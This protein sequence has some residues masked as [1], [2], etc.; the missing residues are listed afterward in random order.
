MERDSESGDLG[1]HP[2][3][4]LVGFGSRRPSTKFPGMVKAGNSLKAPVGTEV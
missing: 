2:G 3:S 4:A 1:P